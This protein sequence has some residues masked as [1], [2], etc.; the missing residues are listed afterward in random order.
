MGRAG[1]ASLD[2]GGVH[3]AQQ[4]LEVPGPRLLAHLL[5]EGQFA[6]VVGVA[7]RMAVGRVVPVAGPSVVDADARIAGEDAHGRERGH[8]AGRVAGVVR[9]VFGAGDMCPALPRARRPRGARARLVVV[10][11]RRA[12]QRALD[13]LGGGAW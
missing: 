7:Q 10:R 1:R 6:Q 9:Q 8:P 2:H 11:H 12:A 3:L 5:D 13:L 4:R